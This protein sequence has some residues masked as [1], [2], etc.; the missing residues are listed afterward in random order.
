MPPRL[1][2]TYCPGT[3]NIKTNIVKGGATLLFCLLVGRPY[4]V[5]S[6]VFSNFCM[7]HSCLESLSR[8]CGFQSTR[9]QL[10]RWHHVQ[11]DDLSGGLV[12]SSDML[13]DR[14]HGFSLASEWDTFL[15]TLKQR[16][17]GGC[18]LV[19]HHKYPQRGPVSKALSSSQCLW[20]VALWNPLL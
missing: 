5:L 14:Q 12:C 17:E 8:Y 1:P 18:R 6:L 15:Q 13:L 10:G 16:I 20:F 9:T 7:H 2:R 4:A 3:K 19:E 11:S